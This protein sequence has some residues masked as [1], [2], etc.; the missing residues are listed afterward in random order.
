MLTGQTGESRSIF[1]FV[2]KE[3]PQEV[4]RDRLKCYNETSTYGALGE[5]R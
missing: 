5:V 1:E 3:T 4:V 2:W